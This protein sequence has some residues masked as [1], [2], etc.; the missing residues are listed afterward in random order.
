[1]D[2]HVTHPCGVVMSK[3]TV[4]NMPLSKNELIVGRLTTGVG[5][6]NHWLRCLHFID[7][8]P[9]LPKKRINILIVGQ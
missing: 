3:A 1:M 7:I 2:A 6:T 9:P 4:A 8:P 5:I